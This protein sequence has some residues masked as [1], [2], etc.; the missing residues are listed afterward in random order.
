MN[1]MDQRQHVLWMCRSATLPYHR[2]NYYRRCGHPVL[3]ALGTYQ[4]GPLPRYN[5][6]SPKGSTKL[7]LEN[8]SYV[9]QRLA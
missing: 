8:A 9:S 2:L 5:T 1:Q 6:S 7:D 4:I 3:Y